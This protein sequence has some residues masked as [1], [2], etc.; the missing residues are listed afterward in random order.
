MNQPESP[1]VL[2]A[3]V[4]RGLLE[5]T[6]HS[7]PPPVTAEG[8][9]AVRLTW[10]ERTLQAPQPLPRDASAPELV[11]LP[12]LTD[13]HVHLDKAFT[14]GSHPNL[15]GTYDGALTANLF[16]HQTRSAQAVLERVCCSN[17]F[18]VS[19]PS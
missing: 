4:P 17:R 7:D 15:A 10:Q 12:R 2:K 1:P 14:W 3:C 18:A 9:T 5:I 19:A 11:V 8:L 6:G 13:P 16:E